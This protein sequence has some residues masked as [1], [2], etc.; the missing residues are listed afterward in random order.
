MTVA[1]RTWAAFGVFAVTGGLLAGCIGTSPDETDAEPDEAAQSGLSCD[2]DS[3]AIEAEEA[4]D[5]DGREGERAE[6]FPGAWP[7]TG[8]DTGS[9]YQVYGGGEE[10][11]HRDYRFVFSAEGDYLFC[12]DTPETERGETFGDFT[13]EEAVIDLGDEGSFTALTWNADAMTWRNN[14]SGSTVYLQRR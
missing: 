1:R 8:F 3:P 7:R 11:V 4:V 13:L 14:M 9:G 5:P 6:L 12:H 10:P 2:W